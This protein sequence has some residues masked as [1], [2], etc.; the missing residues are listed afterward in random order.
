MSL[1]T[2][3]LAFNTAEEIIDGREYRVS[4]EKVF[5]LAMRS[6]CTAYACEYV[7]LAEELGVPLVTADRRILKAFPRIALS[8]EQFAKKKK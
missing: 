4:S 8:L 6:K 3:Q 7:A 5:E 1:G 2:A